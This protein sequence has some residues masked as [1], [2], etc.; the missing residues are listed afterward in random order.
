MLLRLVGERQRGVLI[1]NKHH[2]VLQHNIN[3]TKMC[4]DLPL[5]L[6]SRLPTCVELTDTTTFGEITI[7]KRGEVIQHC[8]L[9]EQVAQQY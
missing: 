1:G 5:S 2:W 4:E 3:N 9:N 6:L 7:L 8:Q